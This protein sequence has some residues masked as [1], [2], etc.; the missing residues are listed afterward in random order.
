MAF[1]EG[2]ERE[3]LLLGLWSHQGGATP[4]YAMLCSKL[5]IGDII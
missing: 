3:C 4:E 2:R 5:H 1:P